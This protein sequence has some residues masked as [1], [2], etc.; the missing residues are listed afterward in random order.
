[1]SLLRRSMSSSLAEK[2]RSATREKSIL[3][4]EGRAKNIKIPKPAGSKAF[5]VVGIPL[6]DSGLYIVELESEILGSACS[7]SLARCSCRPL[8]W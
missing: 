6:K 8:S 5:E 7:V 3:N 1:V 2:G 4:D